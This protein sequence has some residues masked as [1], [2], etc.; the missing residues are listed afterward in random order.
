MN[1]KWQARGA[2]HP[3]QKYQAGGRPKELKRTMVQGRVT[4]N[5]EGGRS[6]TKAGERYTGTRS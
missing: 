3:R 6:R 4:I 5:C 2:K 1:K